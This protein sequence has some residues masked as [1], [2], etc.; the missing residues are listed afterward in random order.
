MLTSRNNP[1]I[2]QIRG[3]RQRHE[4]E[5]S[6][7]Y[8]VEGI[9]LV[10]EAVQ[11]NAPV[12][13][14]IVAPDLL[15][16]SFARDLIAAQ[17]QAGVPY[18]EV[19]ADV[20][21]SVS[22]KDGPQ[23]IG[24]VLRQRWQPLETIRVDAGLGWV[25]L[26]SVADPGN[27]GT[28]LRT[29]DAVGITGVILLGTS[30]D[31]YDPAA[32]RGSMGAIYNQRL[33][34][35]AWD[36]FVAWKERHSVCIVGTSDQAATDYQAVSYT[37]PLVL[38]MGSERQGLSAEQQAACD[39]LVSIPMVGRSDSLNLAVATAVVLYELFNQQR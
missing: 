17:R 21:A 38:L 10:A 13:Q 2:K 7:L 37:L 28:I 16:S 25:A 20:F 22:G 31:P 36:E 29:A 34:R 4:R 3:L 18:L 19:S 11:S 35:A 8:F 6:G 14:L 26:E 24:A 23:G 15:H 32:L 27:L 33:V 30:T 39:L 5:T 9:R 1:T 12:E